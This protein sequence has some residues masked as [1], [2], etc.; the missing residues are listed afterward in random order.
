M[1]HVGALGAF[2]ALNKTAAPPLKLLAGS[3]ALPD[4]LSY[5]LRRALEAWEFGSGSDYKL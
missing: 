3:K 4:K 1:V 5:S 2:T